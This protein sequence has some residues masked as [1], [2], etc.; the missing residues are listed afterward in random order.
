MGVGLA[1]AGGVA[2]GMLAERLLH[3]DHEE[4]SVP[5][6]GGGSGGGLLPGSFESDAGSAADELGRRGIDFGRG[7][8]WD[9]GTSNDFGGGGSD[10][11]G[12]SDW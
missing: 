7:D 12:S 6:D 8:G 5:R 10:S 3:G 9:S 4:R 11:G 2:A 1:A